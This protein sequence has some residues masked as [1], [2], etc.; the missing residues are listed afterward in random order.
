[1]FILLY[2]FPLKLSIFIIFTIQLVF[3]FLMLLGFLFWSSPFRNLYD[4]CSLIGSCFFRLGKFF[5]DFVEKIFCGIDLIFSLFL[6]FLSFIDLVF[7]SFLWFLDIW[8]GLCGEYFWF[9]FFFN[10]IIFVFY[11]VFHATNSH[12]H[13]LFLVSKTCLWG[14][15]HV[16]K[17][18]I[19]RFPVSLGFFNDSIS[20]SRSWALLLISFYCFIVFS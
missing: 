17:F 1:M 8:V 11:L 19:S 5:Y 7:S 14:S 13:L 9:D 20:I 2:I 12:F 18:F 3:C 15:C 4:P 16:T 10:Q 6:H